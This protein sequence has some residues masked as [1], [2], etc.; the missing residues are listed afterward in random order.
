[1]KSKYLVALL[2]VMVLALALRLLN[3]NMPL[4]GDET[5]TWAYS[6]RSPII[7][8]WNYA[9][10][11][12]T[13]PL[14]YLLNHFM[15]QSL[16]IAPW[17]LRLLSVIFGI[18]IIPIVFWGMQEATFSKLNGLLAI[19][20]IATSSMLIYYSQE[21]RAYAMLAFLSTLS[22]ILLFRYFQKHDLISLILYS[23]SMIL[24]TF[25]HRYGYL[26]IASFFISS[27]FF[28]QWRA[29]T[30]NLLFLVLIIAGVFIQF[31]NDSISYG[32]SGDPIDINAIR[33]LIIS[34]SNGTLG[35]QTIVKI[36]NANSLKFPQPVLNQFLQGLGVL[37]I[38]SVI[39]IFVKNRRLFNSKQK[40]FIT[41]LILSIGIPTIIAIILGSGILPQPQ[42]LLRGLIFIWPFYFMLITAGLSKS[43]AILWLVPVIIV[44]N[45]LSLYPYYISYERF[46][47][48]NA[49]N[50]INQ[51]VSEDELIISDPFYMYNMI[52]YYYDGPAPMIGYHPNYGWVDVQQMAS[53]NEFGPIPLENT[54]N[55]IGDIYFYYGRFHSDWIESFPEN[56][57]FYY[58]A[59]LDSWLENRTKRE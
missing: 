1:M 40:Q 32:A 34:L 27:I 58:N 44:I 4:W 22:V 41:L 28:R 50:Q 48:V 59:E 35:M 24:I 38:F 43:K 16:G 20:L 54:P 12:P 52:D 33:S 11:T 21:A 55:P 10:H 53:S 45:L 23:I 39:L 46:S 17:A 47:N 19:L 49:F 9:S 56:N 3:L 15:I 7:E 5:Q 18:L 30:I 37:V 36:P 14:Y 57:I 25:T 42:W 6:R 26:L 29:A 31:T 13:P 51:R 2:C 8:L